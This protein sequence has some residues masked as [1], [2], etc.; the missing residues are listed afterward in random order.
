MKR[1]LISLAVVI[2][3]WHQPLL[4]QTAGDA[5]GD[6]VPDAEDCAPHDPTVASMHR[7]YFDL[8]GDQF[9]DPQNPLYVCSAMPFPGSTV[10]G[11]DPDDHNSAIT[12]RLVPRGARRLGVDFL[13]T[14]ES[15]DWQTTWPRELGADATSLTLSWSLI[16]T[17][18]G[19]FDG[20]QAA[21]LS[22]LKRAYV[23]D[24]FALNLTISPITQT[25]L[26]LPADLAAGVQAG[27]RSFSDP[28]VIA[29]FNALLDFVHGALDGVPLV[30]LQIGH[31][32]DLYLTQRSDP[33]F[34]AG[35]A[36]F[37]AATQAH[38]KSLWGSS[39]K[40]GITST[41]DGILT[42]PAASLMSALNGMTDL[43]SVTYLPHNADF[44]AID[45][46]RVPFDVYALIGRT[47]PK[48]VSFHSVGYPSAPRT[49]SSL[50]QQAQFV[51]AFFDAWDRF[52]DL[53]PYAGFA[54]LY[55]FAPARAATDAAAPHLHVPVQYAETAAAWLGS[56]G[57]RT[58]TGA[59]VHKPAYQSL[60][61]LTLNRGWWSVPPLTSRSFLLGFTPA[62]YDHNPGGPLIPEV[63]DTLSRDIATRAD[64]VAFHFDGGIP[65][66]E[67]LADTFASAEPPYSQNLR[68][69]WAAH[70]AVT[71]PGAR[72]LVAIN[73]LGIPRSVLAPY[74]GP[75]E[76]FYH[77]A[78]FNRVGT[79]VVQDYQERLLPAPWNTYRLNAPQVKTAFLNYARRAID[80][81]HADYLVT[82]IEVNLAFQE[83]PA[84]Y[85]DYVELQQY[86]YEHLKSD[87]RYARVKVL[88]SFVAEFLVTDEFGV[89]LTEGAQAQGIQTAHLGAL[90][91]L[92]PYTDI[93]GLSLYPIKTR[94]LAYQLPAVIFDDLFARLR[95]ITNKPIAIT[96]T[97]YPSS[98]FT[99]QDLVFQSDAEKQA[100]YVR[101]LFS[102][103]Q[104]HGGVEFVTYFAPRDLVPHIDKLVA[105][106]HESPPYISPQLVE[107]YRY[108]EFIG[109]LDEHGVARPALADFDTV[110]A[111]PVDR[112]GRPD[113]WIA[114]L[115]LAS[116]DG[117][118]RAVLSV[119]GQGRLR[120]AIERNGVTMLEPSPLGVTV[121]GVDL[122]TGAINMTAT[123]PI[124][125]SSTYP[126]LGARATATDHH[127]EWTVTV[128]R[129]GSGDRACS[130]VFRLFDAGVGYR[131]VVPGSGSRTIGGEASG[132]LLPAGSIVWH[133]TNTDNYESPYREAP[134]GSF[135][136]NLG[137]PLTIDLPD[138]N[139][140]LWISEARL[141]DYTGLAFHANLA[142][143][144]ITAQFLDE[145][146]WTVA[147]GS[148]TPWRVTMV[149]PTLNGLAAADLVGHLNDPPDPAL[150][151]Q[152]PHTP[153][154]KPGKAVW[155]WWSDFYSGYSF[156]TQVQFVN[157]AAQLGCE[158][159]IV[160]AWWELGFPAGGLDQFQRLAQLV[161]YAHQDGRHVDIWVWK[162]WH[163]LLQPEARAAFLQQV[164]AAGAVGVKIDNVYA[165]D[166]ESFAT[167]QQ[168]ERILRDAAGLQLM[169]NFHGANKATGLSRT[170][171]NEITR[172]GFMGMEIDGLLW[173]Q[174]QFVTPHHNAALPFVRML[175][176]PGDYTPV[177]F[178]PRK[179]GDTTVAQQLALAGLFTSPLLTYA[180]HPA[181]LQWYPEVQDLLRTMPTTWDETLVLPFSEIGRVAAL[182]RRKGTRWYVFAINGDAQAAL[183]VQ[184]VVLA[185]LG[186]GAYDA[187]LVGDQTKNTFRRLTR[188]VTSQDQVDIAML[189]GGG[190]V[191][192]FQPAGDTPTAAASANA[193][194]AA[195]ADVA[196]PAPVAESETVATVVPR[197]TRILSLDATPTEMA[198][199]AVETARY[200]FGIQG[201]QL[202]LDWKDIETAPGIYD[203]SALDAINSYYSAKHIAVSLTIRPV[204]AIHKNVPADLVDTAFDDA[205]MIYRF[206]RLLDFVFARLTTVPLASV[207]IGNEVDEYFRVHQETLPAYK[208]FFDVSVYHIKS[209]RPDVKVGFTANL[210][211]LTTS[212]NAGLLQYLNEFS[213]VVLV[214]YYPMN[215]DFTV[216]G[217]SVVAAD[218]DAL[219]ARYWYKPI[220]F[221]EAG[222]PSGPE[223]G[224][225]EEQQRQFI[226]EMFAAW[227]AHASQIELISFFRLTDFSP[228]QVD[229]YAGYYD[230]SGSAEFRG[231]LASLGLRAW[232][233]Y[234]A[235]KPAFIQFYQEAHA[236]GW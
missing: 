126:T 45:T 194:G 12:G 151:P 215:F 41:Y 7:Y 193:T 127:V 43:V 121:D 211:A 217:P 224:G 39:L 115:T 214:L 227:D 177:T 164:K 125:S 89:P 69:W 174:G 196:A 203:A 205:R 231:F 180:D 132:W 178:D 186:P 95:G 199:E 233:G 101:F 163:E 131:Y 176:G 4:A 78:Q 192:T 113:T 79:G 72:V 169:V 133:E 70:R 96:E 173:A 190:F 90:Q 158:Y 162:N 1:W 5:D 74:W 19:Q 200:Y 167:V 206:G 181:V 29:R 17:A 155:S 160:D 188:R 73:P 14:S 94:Y 232:S 134:I 140:F 84:F 40:V 147:G 201:V 129:S 23:R 157:Y 49:K 135:N 139:G 234:G 146:S 108:F 149:S 61:Q 142:S 103:M 24:G 128:R 198:D 11:S 56:M 100:R 207:A 77:D 112:A 55:D 104:K 122:G 62:L 182:A 68:D 92:L 187:V 179:M 25:W 85:D 119:D 98:S 166:S 3:V 18:P 161:A 87:P 221:R 116:P 212:G 148:A 184:S 109:L 27:T 136:D 30:S 150:F 213:D 20:A 191:G 93:V 46:A 16:E 222:Y 9:G 86:V 32:A 64:F 110:S 60:R 47:F 204:D 53:I 183:T 123:A 144:L 35:F 218:V 36:Q 236:R 82:G 37:Y 48:P 50:T 99:V 141:R 34:W 209:L 81:F 138:T 170:Y 67:A 165:T 152:G 226:A 54:R 38:A 107:F 83:N 202:M 189:P 159:V 44:T 145:T 120:Y 10:W 210:H 117:L 6:G 28:A 63:L 114:P 52:P 171:P 2:L 137:G 175:A 228:A 26:A 51:Q 66:P 153:W 172:E 216:R 208:T 185:F 230:Q 168:Y 118:L 124:D 58:W 71:P 229:Y 42:E 80:Y 76:G 91:R 57:L 22:I 197:G 219:T 75:G 156:D 102:E 220:H 13:D 223:T 111:L 59:G 130:L 21:A 225:S 97:G 195:A 106:S 105:R 8:D 33:Q 143:R 235:W 88:V 15:G 31:E 154:I 65:W